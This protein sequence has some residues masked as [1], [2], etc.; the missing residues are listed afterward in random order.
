[1]ALGA[2]V[3]LG[4]G[5]FYSNKYKKDDDGKKGSADAPKILSIPEDQIQQIEIRRKDGKNTVLKKTDKWQITAPEALAADQDAVNGVVTAVATLNSDRIVEEKPAELATFG[6]AAPEVEVTVTQ[7]DGKATKLQ[8]GDG[9]ATGSGFFAKLDGDP[10]VYTINSSS[11]TSIDKTAQELRDRR[12]IAFDSEKLSRVELTAKGQTVEF[13]KNQQNEWQMVKPKPLRADNWAV[14][15]LVR[16]LKDAKMEAN[17]SEE[18]AKKAAASFA[19]GSKVAVA[20][21]TDASGTH[22]VEVRKKDKDYFAKG[23]AIGGFHKV[24]TDLGEGL[25]KG[26]DDFRS[27][28]LFDFGFNDPTRLEV[29]AGAGPVKVYT[30]SGEKWMLGGQQMDSVSVQ[31]FVD[32]LRD[33]SSVKFVDAGFTAPVF[34]VKLTAKDGKLVDHVQISQ[35]DKS[36][37]AIR[38]GEPSIYELDAT[39]A[40]DLQKVAEDIKPP[41]PPSAPAKK[42]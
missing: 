31:S 1:V 4:A 37:Y 5:V 22:E 25:D 35:K 8:I 3:I 40:A 24:A 38:V 15:E 19:T 23:S 26:P 9:T 42:K 18:D 30:K 16:K 29:K 7:K 41:A 12:L 6:L 27:K 14:E 36:F 28:K 21:M 2:L 10:K 34:D 11:K 39:A 20:K 13:G 33:L 32:K 17:V